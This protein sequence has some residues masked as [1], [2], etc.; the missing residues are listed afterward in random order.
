[1]AGGGL[2]FDFNTSSWMRGIYA[3]CKLS[4]SAYFGQ[5]RPSAAAVGSIFDNVLIWRA[6]ECL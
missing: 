5:H 2:C 4:V 1:L 6:F 3:N